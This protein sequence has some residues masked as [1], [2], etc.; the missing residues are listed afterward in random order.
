MV[1]GATT[2]VKYLLFLA[3]FIL[4]VRDKKILITVE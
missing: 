4:W 1:E 3:N 2:L